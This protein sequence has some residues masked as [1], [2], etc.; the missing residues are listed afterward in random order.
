[1]FSTKRFLQRVLR[2]SDASVLMFAYLIPFTNLPIQVS[3]KI[4]HVNGVAYLLR[5]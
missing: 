4:N 2:L 5:R 1:M 3:V